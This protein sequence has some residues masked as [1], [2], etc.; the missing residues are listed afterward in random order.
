M[1]LMTGNRRDFLRMA[2]AATAASR[3]R[4]L[5]A[6]D[7]VRLG[8]IGTGERGRYLI[9][10]ASS[11]G[12]CEIAALCDVYGPRLAA[13]KQKLSPGAREFADY[14][15]LLSLNDIDAVVIATPDHWHAP[16]A[17]DALR[18]GKD[19]YLEK[20]VTH[21]PQEGPALE[22]AVRATG[23]VV[24]AGYQQ[25]SWAHFSQARDIVRAGKLGNIALLAASW[26]QNYLPHGPAPEIAAADLD[27]K[28]F[29]GSAPE[30]PFDTARFRD[31]RW[32]WDFGGGHLTDLYSHYADVV[33]WFMD[34]DMPASASATGQSFVI[35]EFQ[36]PDTISAAFTYP[37]GHLVCYYGT[38]A[39]EQHDN[40]A[41]QG[42]GGVMQLS[43]QGFALYPANG[44]SE[45]SLTARSTGDGT[46]AHV[47]NFL[48]CVRTR[49]APNAPIKAAIA[50]AAAAHLGNA[51][52]RRGVRL[53]T[54]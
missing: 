31:W 43:R 44:G 50:A 34:E 21:R 13:A 36:C 39:T 54:R 19:V 41:I 15:E 48:D 45:P 6:N 14:R 24:Q 25:R 26:S 10:I 23:R 16:M 33:H 7:R 8:G 11:I 4:I 46:V 37:R 42:S 17:L 32:F 20:P 22:Q 5:G 52:L 3:G 49:Q 29:L 2:A 27:W 1:S 38:L 30:Q 40:L 18:A 47:R 28:R 51:A 35:P 53:E 12:G 9:E